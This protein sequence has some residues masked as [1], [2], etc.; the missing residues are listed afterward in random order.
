MLGSLYLSFLHS[1]VWQ[2]QESMYQ[3]GDQWRAYYK[4]FADPTLLGNFVDN[5]DNARFMNDATDTSLYQGALGW[6]ML[7][8]GIP[9]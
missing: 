3:L 4:D 8:D 6:V 9:M 2:S 1:N 5:H 7:S